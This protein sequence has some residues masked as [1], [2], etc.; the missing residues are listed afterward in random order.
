VLWP[1]CLI[2]LLTGPVG[3][4]PA[5]G[6]PRAYT[7]D[8]HASGVQVLLARSG[9]LSAFAHDHVLVA[10][11]FAG[12]VALDPGDL[13]SAALQVTFPVA[14]LIVDPPEARA[15][16]GLDGSL[17][18]KDRASIRATLLSAGQ[19]DAERF[20]RVVATLEGVSGTLPDLLLALR[21][22]VREAEQVLSVPVRVEA[23]PDGLRA[24]G[25]FTFLQ[26][27]FGIRPYRALLGAIAVEDEARVRFD[28]VARV[29]AR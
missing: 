20:P 15:A 6:Q 2:W 17:S 10:D 18:E 26:S 16:A 25:E 12:G 8:P 22:R 24:S 28:I 14:S 21:V 11:G 27:A 23:T 3:S 5:W 13:S 9:P 29:E 1:A 4:G 7:I 19:L